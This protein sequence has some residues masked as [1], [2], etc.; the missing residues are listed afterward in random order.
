MKG[1]CKYTYEVGAFGHVKICL[2]FTSHA[3]TVK[4]GRI[5]F[6]ITLVKSGGGVCKNRDYK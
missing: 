1:K 6:F 2:L 5:F 4:R 3:D